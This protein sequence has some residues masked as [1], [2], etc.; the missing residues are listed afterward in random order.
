MLAMRILVRIAETESFTKAADQMHLSVPVVTRA[1]ANLESQLGTRLLHRT[2]RSVTLTEAGKQYVDGAMSML[3]QLDELENAL[4]ESR[5]GL[6]G[7]LRVVASAGFGLAGL[8][9]LLKSY[10]DKYPEVVLQVAT[11]DRPVNLVSEGYDVGILVDHTITSEN[12]IQRPLATYGRILVASPEYVKV[13]GPAR[14]PGDLLNYRFLSEETGSN[15]TSVELAFRLAGAT[16]RIR[17]KPV[18]LTPSPWLLRQ[19]L[20]NSMG[21]ALIPRLFVEDDLQNGQ[22]VELMPETELLDRSAIQ[23]LVYPTRRHMNSRLRT[24]IDHM[25]DAAGSRGGPLA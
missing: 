4:I 6:S 15:A 10:Q 18:F 9:P 24:F 1:I 22:L 20:V 12:L 2:T 13:A 25:L 7:L 23:S 14:V 8:A 11:V 19:A 5:A 21:F 17:V 16:E 3:G